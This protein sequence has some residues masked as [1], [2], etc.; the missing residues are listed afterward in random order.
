[1]KKIILILCIIISFLNGSVLSQTDSLCRYNLSANILAGALSGE[2]GFYFDYQISRF[3]V[4]R[5]SYAHR[6]WQANIIENGGAGSSIQYLACQS[7]VVRF[8]LKQYFYIPKKNKI[9]KYYV[10][11]Q[12]VYMK[13]NT[14][15]YTTRYGSNGL[16]NIPRAV[17]SVDR[18][19]LG[20]SVGFGKT[21]YKSSK[22]FTETFF[23]FGL[24]GGDKT[25][26]KYSGGNSGDGNEFDHNPDIVIKEKGIFPIIDIGITIGYCWQKGIK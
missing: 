25:T 14:P 24:A 9:G 6:F 12:A 26:T 4:L 7:D 11:A 22:S 5:S 23:L 18:S 13:M 10:V 20:G 8:G 3:S 16:N 19:M 17:I 21:I 2:A 15:K 1:M